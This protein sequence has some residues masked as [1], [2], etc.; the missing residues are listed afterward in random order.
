MN[1]ELKKLIRESG[2]KQY[3]FAEKIGIS[4]NT[5][6]CY[7]MGIRKP[8]YDTAVKMAEILSKYLD[9]EVEEIF[10]EIYK[11]NYDKLKV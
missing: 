7:I 3:I 11:L 8:K 4:G 1:R 5:L 6:S 10:F 9:R 2:L